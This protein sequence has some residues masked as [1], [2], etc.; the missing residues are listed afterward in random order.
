M[1]N[2]NDRSAAAQR[3]EQ[4]LVESSE[5][6]TGIVQS[7]T[8]AIIVVDEQQ[9]ILLFNAAAA[10][11]FGCPQ[12]EA[13]GTH[14]ERFVPPRFRAGHAAGFERVRQNDLGA[15][16]LG[17][18][19]TLCGLRATGQEFPCEASIAQ[20][21]VGGQR[22][23]TVIIRDITERQRSEEALRRRVEFESFLFDFSRTFIGLPDDMV[24]ANMEQGLGRLGHFLQMDRITLLE[25]SY[26][27]EELT[28]AYSWSAAGV[29]SL[30]PVLTKHMQ[31]W[32]VGQVLRGDVSVASRVDD[33]PAEAVAERQYLRQRGVASAVSI[34]SGSPARLPEP[35]RSSRSTATCRGLLSC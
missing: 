11:M 3:S 32:W 12:Q 16:H 1:A 15:R 27:R 21:E 18:L 9:R 4:L 13:I 24:D 33:L 17:L 31:P 23:F 22:E 8:D 2:P 19:P 28:V 14:L 20:H 35:Y 29:A 25:L 26:D 34:R 10:R 7:A 5:R 6:L 30:P